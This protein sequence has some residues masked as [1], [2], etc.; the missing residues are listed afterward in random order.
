MPYRFTELK[1]STDRNRLLEKL[2]KILV[3]MVVV[4]VLVMSVVAI[5]TTM[6]K[7][8]IYISKIN[9]FVN[10]LVI[11]ESMRLFYN[12]RPVYYYYYYCH[13][14]HHHHHHHL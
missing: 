7:V 12:R 11:S 9:H 14:H 5:G 13:H 1:M 10:P 8:F 4:V 2:K 6:W 3:V